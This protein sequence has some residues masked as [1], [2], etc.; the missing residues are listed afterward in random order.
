MTDVGCPLDQAFNINIDTNVSKKK[1]KKKKNIKYD[2]DFVVE[3]LKKHNLSS[4]DNK[5]NVYS[6]YEE[7]KEEVEVDNEDHNEKVIK[8]TN[9]EYD[10][11][12]EYQVNRFIKSK[13]K[14]E[15]I[16]KKVKQVNNSD[17]IETFSL[18]DDN[19]E[20]N[21]LLL[22]LIY[23]ILYIVLIDWIYKL[24]RKGY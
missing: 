15:V 6:P 3:Q 19:T 9:E 10:L 17:L 18:S 14:D 11:Y 22:F 12:K 24:G 8:L 23:G 16:N 7:M 4:F 2:D 21:N 5:Y 13:M 20:F 1:K